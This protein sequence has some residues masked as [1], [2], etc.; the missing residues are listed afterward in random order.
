[1]AYFHCSVIVPYILTEMFF[2]DIMGHDSK[3]L[4]QNEK[5]S[6]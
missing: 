1:M 3:F 5:K 4:P 2:T 6:L